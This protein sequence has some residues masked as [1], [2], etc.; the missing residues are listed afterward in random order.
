MRKFHAK[1]TNFKISNKNSLTNTFFAFDQLFLQL[2][3]NKFD[4][5]GIINHV[6]L[7]SH[8]MHFFSMRVLNKC[9]K[10]KKNK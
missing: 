1:E 7:L 4:W 6:I 2:E 10:Y 3:L 5:Y 8:S 9:I